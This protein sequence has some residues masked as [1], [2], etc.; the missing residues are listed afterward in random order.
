MKDYFK[1]LGY[2][3]DY[4]VLP[5]GKHVQLIIIE[6]KSQFE[7]LL[8]KFKGV[9]LNNDQLDLAY[10]ESVNPFSLRYGKLSKIYQ[11]SNGLFAVDQGIVNKSVSYF[12]CN[13]IEDYKIILE[14]LHLYKIDANPDSQK[15]IECKIYSG[16]NKIKVLLNSLP[17]KFIEEKSD[18][19]Y[20]LFINEDGKCF[21]VKYNSKST[22]SLGKNN[23]RA[24][25]PTRIDE[26]DN[27]ESLVI[28]ESLYVMDQ[29]GV[30][31]LEYCEIDEIN[32]KAHEKILLTKL[33]GQFNIGIIN[34]SSNYYKKLKEELVVKTETIDGVVKEIKA[35]QAGI[36]VNFQNNLSIR[37]KD[38]ADFNKFVL[39]QGN[40]NFFG[41]QPPQLTQFITDIQNKI[42]NRSQL[43]ALCELFGKSEVK[44]VTMSQELTALDKRINMYLFDYK[45]INQYF[46]DIA[47]MIGM[48]IIEKEKASWEVDYQSGMCKIITKDGLSIDFISYLF[49]DMM[50]QVYTGY[51]SSVALIEGLIIGAKLASPIN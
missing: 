26:N 15:I 20:K 16:H 21:Y 7:D 37:F 36:F 47:V 48:I 31:D 46:S 12:L 38:E 25:N 51:C 14:Y 4:N 6:H 29:V 23:A 2:Y 27:Y 35:G 24:S 28:Y 41:G 44:E 43:S 50:K 42:S 5:A 34:E 40:S 1:E 8:A 49:E 9:Q 33:G 10:K 13:S 30:L 11:L 22:G 18:T 39:L 32:F 45:F 3:V 19:N 17:L